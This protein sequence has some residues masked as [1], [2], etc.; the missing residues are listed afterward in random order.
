MKTGLVILLAALAVMNAVTFC[1]YAADKNKAKRGKWRIP[2]STLILMSFL[3]G[4]IGAM[5][6]MFLLRHKTKHA[7][8]L[9]LVPLSLV[10]HIALAVWLL[11]FR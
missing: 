11:F 8:F 6:G 3:G 5:A 9:I 4:S 10:L 7:K 1:L 2:E